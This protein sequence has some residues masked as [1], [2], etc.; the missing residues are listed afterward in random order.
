MN[1]DLFDNMNGLIMRER[2][3]M[4]SVSADNNSAEAPMPRFPKNT[5]L[6]IAYVPFQQWSEVYTD[7][8]ALARGTLFP[9]LDLPFGRG[10][11]ENE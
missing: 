3:N 8:H 5:P 9:E 2:E 7:D 6:G 11:K 10:G 1:L 4:M